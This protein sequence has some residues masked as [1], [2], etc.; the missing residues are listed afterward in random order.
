MPPVEPPHDLRGGDAHG[1]AVDHEG[2]AGVHLHPR[3]GGHHDHGGHLREK[4]ILALVAFLYVIRYREVHVANL[5]VLYLKDLPLMFAL[6]CSA[7]P[8]RGSKM[9]VL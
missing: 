6:H 5:I 4:Y 3:R 8:F 9:L 1:G 2:E 7:R